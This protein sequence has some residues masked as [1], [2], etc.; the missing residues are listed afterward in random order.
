MKIF[1]AVMNWGLGHATRCVPLIH[2]FLAQGDEVILGGEGRSLQLLRHYFPLLPFLELPAYNIKYADSNQQIPILLR[3][4]PYL[5]RTF[6]A[7]HAFL[8]KQIPL[9]GIEKV[10]SD[11]RYGLWSKQVPCVF[12]THQL[13]PIAPLFWLTHQ[14]HKF[15]IRKFTE[16]WIPDSL[17]LKLAGK[18]AHQF[19]LPAN[20]SFIGTLSHFA[21]NQRLTSEF[22]TKVLANFPPPEILAIL[23]G[24]EPQRTLFSEIIQKEAKKTT[25][26]IWLVE[27]KTEKQE[28]ISVGNLTRITYLDAADLQ[29]AFAF[30]PIVISRSGYS[31][32]MDYHFLKLKKIVLV[33]TPGQT[34]QEYLAK[35]L[36]EK[37]ISMKKK[38]QSFEILDILAEIKNYSGFE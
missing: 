7:E 27:G 8:E 24:P 30:A 2:Q 22:M 20:A 23:S 32:L 6:Q 25:K 37:K 10:I 35:M 33:P 38:Q 11:N 31:S 12:M 18:M 26:N 3:Q 9:L 14:L 5:L 36:F 21:V 28:V 16:I 19:P 4:I 15:A 29:K 1:L 34:E 17:E 13:A